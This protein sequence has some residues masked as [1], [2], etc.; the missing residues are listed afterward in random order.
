MSEKAPKVFGTDPRIGLLGLVVLAMFLIP[1]TNEYRDWK[2][3]VVS[4]TSSAVVVR[5]LASTETTEVSDNRAK[6]LEPGSCVLVRQNVG[7]TLL[8]RKIFIQERSVPC[9]RS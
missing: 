1:E 9:E 3:E 5:Q 2:A 4:T 7:F 8:K 6:E